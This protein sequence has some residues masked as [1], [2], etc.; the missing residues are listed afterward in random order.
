MLSPIGGVCVLCIPCA[1][2]KASMNTLETP[3]TTRL[4][5]DFRI[6]STF[7]DLFLMY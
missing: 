7:N 2:F 5:N 6:K 3:E 1:K 4:V